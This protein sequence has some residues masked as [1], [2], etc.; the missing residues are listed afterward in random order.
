MSIYKSQLSKELV[1]NLYN[2]Q[3]ARLDVPYHDIFVQT[4]FGKTHIVEIGN[5]EGKPLLV[6]HG[7]NSSTA[8]NLL[9]CRFLLSDFHVYAVDIIGQPGKSAENVL[10]PFGYHYGRWAGE[11]ISALGY[12]KMCCF[13]G[14]FGGGVLVKLMCV[15][16]QKVEKAVLIVPAGIANVS[17]KTAAK[18]LL[19]LSK[20][21]LTKD[22]KYIVETVLP[23]ALSTK[24]LSAERLAT[25]KNSFDHVRIQPIMPTN[26][27]PERLHRCQAKTLVVAAEKDCLFPARRIL[28]KV[29]RILPNCKIHMLKGCGHIHNLPKREK[30][31]IVD[32]LMEE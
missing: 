25:I 28:P 9:E 11:V 16:P 3:I 31:I 27:E 12:E 8:Y 17:V 19:P 30:N 23:M 24:M 32:F 1:I 10:A 4:S 26:A 14:S 7:G 18:M 15:A 20:Y 5:P 13:G 6:F 2:A 22:E 29:K 21:Y